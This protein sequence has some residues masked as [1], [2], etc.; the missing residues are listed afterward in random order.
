LENLG[1]TE[2]HQHLTAKTDFALLV[3]V[4]SQIL[5][6]KTTKTIRF[7]ATDKIKETWEKN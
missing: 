2:S 5:K 3:T 1:D 6:K 7:V 4:S